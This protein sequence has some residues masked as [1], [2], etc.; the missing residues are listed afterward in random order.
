MATQQQLEERLTVINEQLA[1]WFS[2]DDSDEKNAQ[3]AIWEARKQEIEFAL[4]A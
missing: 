1:K 4:N 2:E 3:I